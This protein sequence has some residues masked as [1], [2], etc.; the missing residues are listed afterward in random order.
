MP[1]SP[2][3]SLVLQGSRVLIIE[4]DEGSRSSCLP[5][6]PYIIFLD[7][8]RNAL[9]QKS[10]ALSEYLSAQVVNDSTSIRR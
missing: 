6:H 2:S 1:A 5:S 3:S 9:E 4:T 8:A 7:S 10:F